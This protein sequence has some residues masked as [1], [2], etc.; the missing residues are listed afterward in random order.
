MKKVTIPKDL[1]AE[2]DA[3]PRGGKGKSHVWTD[4]QDAV[5]VKLMGDGN[6]T[7]HNILMFFKKHYSFGSDNVL[8]HR[9]RELT[10]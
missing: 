4:E 1:L 6:I 10:K 2:L 9:Y 5:L 3:I 8:R 7:Q